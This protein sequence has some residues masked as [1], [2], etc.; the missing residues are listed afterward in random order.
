MIFSLIKFSFSMS[1][2]QIDSRFSFPNVEPDQ[3]DKFEIR[4]SITDTLTA[5]KYRLL[6]SDLKSIMKETLARLQAKDEKW[7][8]LTEEKQNINNKVWAHMYW[9]TYN[10]LR[11]VNSLNE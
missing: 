1:K 4:C 6:K 9:R 7:E 8:L 2:E 5:F 10:L 3:L 11:D